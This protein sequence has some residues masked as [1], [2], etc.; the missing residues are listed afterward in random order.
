VLG[1]VR[2]ARGRWRGRCALRPINWRLRIQLDHAP[3]DAGRRPTR[4]S[5]SDQFH[6]AQR[7]VS[8][9]GLKRERGSRGL[10]AVAGVEATA[11]RCRWMTDPPI[12]RAATALDASPSP[13]SASSCRCT[14]HRFGH[15]AGCVGSVTRAELLRLGALA[16]STTRRTIRRSPRCSGRSPAGSSG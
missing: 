8:R 1:L 4:R 11:K 15:F 7:M 9:T 14:N 16:S 10:R 12:T 2:G 3:G 13:S 5:D 6:E